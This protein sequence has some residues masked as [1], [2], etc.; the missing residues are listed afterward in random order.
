MYEEIRTGRIAQ[1]LHDDARLVPTGVTML[2]YR[3]GNGKVFVIEKKEFDQRF[4]SISDAE[5]GRRHE[6]G[7]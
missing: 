4:R 3:L 6:L 5:V 7:R 2:V 1:I